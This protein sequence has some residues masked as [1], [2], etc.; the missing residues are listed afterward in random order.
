MK[1]N[2]KNLLISAIAIM[3]IVQLTTLSFATTITVNQIQ[4]ALLQHL[5]VIPQD[6]KMNQMKMMM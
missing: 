1:K 4:M 3:I 6:K 2:G 5:L